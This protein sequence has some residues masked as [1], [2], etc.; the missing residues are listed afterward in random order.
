MHY[1]DESHILLF[2]LQLLALL[3]LARTFGAI[4]ERFKVPA[5]AG[6]ILAGVALGAWLARHGRGERMQV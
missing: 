1:L 6:E 3:G 5:L 2:L 4:C